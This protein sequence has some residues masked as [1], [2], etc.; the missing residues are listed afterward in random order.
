MI[1]IREIPPDTVVMKVVGE[2]AGPETA[3]FDDVI[4]LL[5]Q[6]RHPNKLLDL[7]EVQAMS[8]A[9]IGSIIL[10]RRDLTEGARPLRIQGCHPDLLETLRLMRLETLIQID[11]GPAL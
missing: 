3:R 4:R 7:S 6:Y 8:S 5:M 2:V 1:Y 9:A 11:P 10:A